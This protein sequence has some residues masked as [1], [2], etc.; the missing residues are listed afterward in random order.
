VGTDKSKPAKA[1]LRVQKLPRVGTMSMIK[2]PGN[3][4][5]LK[6]L[7]QPGKKKD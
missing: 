2:G 4:S 3:L 1:R 5:S 6:T 7:V